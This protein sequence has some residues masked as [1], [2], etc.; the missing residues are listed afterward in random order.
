MPVA[1]S[2][3][4]SRR[5]PTASVPAL[6]LLLLAAVAACTSAPVDE[7]EVGPGPTGATVA[8]HQSTGLKQLGALTPGPER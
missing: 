7:A 2:V 1:P 3:G 6:V 5:T 4:A 8:R